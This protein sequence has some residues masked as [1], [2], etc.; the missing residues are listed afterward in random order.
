MNIYITFGWSVHL[1]VNFGSGPVVR[2]LLFNLATTKT[3]Q[4]LW[5]HYSQTKSKL[6]T[7]IWTRFQP[8]TRTLIK[9]ELSWCLD[10]WFIKISKNWNLSLYRVKDEFILVLLTKRFCHWSCK[11]T[12]LVMPS[13]TAKCC[14]C[15]YVYE[16][17]AGFYCPFSLW[18]HILR[19][20]L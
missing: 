19:R 11:S 15:K 13:N 9:K 16:E 7:R 12:C 6:L 3:W 10:F 17:S 4:C 2:A 14:S 20:N 8:K 5:E 1:E 18:W